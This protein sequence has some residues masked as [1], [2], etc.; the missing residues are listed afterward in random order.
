MNI[1][2]TE[3]VEKVIVTVRG[4]RVLLDSD[5]ARI[6]GVSTKRFNEQVRRNINRFPAD[7]MF[8]ITEIEVEFLKSQT[9]TALSEWGGR[10]YL[11]YVFTEYGTVMLASVLNSPI[12]VEASIQITRA[13]INL[14]HMISAHTELAH[15]L[16]L[17]EKKV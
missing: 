10:R 13:F 17:L 9:A 7:F 1:I 11:P 15:K 6:Y 5:L 2:P 8:Q 12:A 14:R 16:D 4:Q 3:Q